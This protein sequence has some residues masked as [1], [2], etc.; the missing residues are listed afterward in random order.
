VRKFNTDHDFFYAEGGSYPVMS[1]SD[2]MHHGTGPQDAAPAGFGL[3]VV[4][5]TA[6][7]EWSGDGVQTAWIG[8]LDRTGEYQQVS[9]T[10]FH[11]KTEPTSTLESLRAAYTHEASGVIRCRR[12][13]GL[14]AIGEF[15]HLT[16]VTGRVDTDTTFALHV[17]ARTV[18]GPPEEHVL[19]LWPATGS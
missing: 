9:L 19:V 3:T 4:T 8:L 7:D 16:T 1:V 15:Q 13:G 11:A 2:Y 6:D 10:V 18:A 17:F 14:E 12:H 5:K